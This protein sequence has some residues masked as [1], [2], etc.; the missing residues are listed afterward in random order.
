MFQDCRV[1]HRTD[2]Q[3]TVAIFSIGSPKLE[4]QRM[5][6][7]VFAATRE[8][9]ISLE[10]VW[11]SRDQPMMVLM[12]KGSRGPWR[13]W[14]DWGLDG[15]TIKLVLARDVSVDAFA[16]K[17]NRVCPAY[18][19]KGFEVEALG[20]D[21]FC[22]D[23]M[24]DQVYLI[25]PHPAEL[26]PALHHAARYKTRVVIVLHM[27]MS[28][29]S[30]WTILRGGHLP[31]RAL[32][33]ILCHPEFSGGRSSP[34]FCGRRNFATCIFDLRLHGNESLDQVLQEKSGLCIFGGCHAC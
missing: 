11:H 23:L 22:Q 33:A 7:D 3:G 4:L 1:R 17:H 14:D 9:N 2:N 27:W 29:Y 32:N 30:T 10:V 8:L 12:D 21:F 25:H 13:H 28:H 15:E 6:E 31:E 26:I 5:A 34:A 24:E 20:Q 19:S 18:F 16:S